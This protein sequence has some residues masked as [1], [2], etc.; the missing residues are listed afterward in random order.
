MKSKVTNVDVVNRSIDRT[1]MTIGV[2]YDYNKDDAGQ[3]A[4]M[5]VDVLRQADTSSANFFKAPTVEVGKSRRNFVLFPVKFQPPT[6]IGT[7]ASGFSTDKVLVYL[8]NDSSK[9]LNLFAATMLLM[10]RAPGAAAPVQVAAATHTIDF[11]DF[12]QKDASDG[13]VAIRYNLIGGAG[14]LRVAIYDSANPAT[15]DYFATS[16]VDVNPGRGLQTLEVKVEPESKSPTDFIRAD[17]IEIEMIDPAGK[18][19]AKTS[20]KASMTWSKPKQ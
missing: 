20:K 5:S 16:Q 13:Y 4:A 6:G 9:R 7:D 15:R 8:T 18:V 3:K 17:T 10:W 14:R 19:L 12:K 11:D 1:Q 2:E